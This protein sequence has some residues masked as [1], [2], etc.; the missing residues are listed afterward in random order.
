MKVLL[1][2]PSKARASTLQKYA[3]QWLSL[4]PA[5]INWMVFVEPQDVPAYADVVPG[6]LYQIDSNDQGLGYALTRIKVYAELNQYDVVFKLDD[7]IRGFMEWRQ[8]LNPGAVAKLVTRMVNEIGEAF[9]KYADLGAV[10]FPYSFEQYEKVVWEPTKR[11]QTAYLVRTSAWFT[12]PRVSVFE[13]FAVGLHCLVK[14]FRVMKYG[15]SAIDM[16]VKVGGGTGGHQSPQLERN[17]RSLATIDELR[18][19]YPPLECKAVDKPWGIEPD[20]RSVKL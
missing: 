16:G 15:L 13:D 10:T 2:I 17:N 8:K 19:I 9:G 14:G 7:D 18:K 11:V 3:L 6:H 12:D 20:L 4:L 1:A 5:E